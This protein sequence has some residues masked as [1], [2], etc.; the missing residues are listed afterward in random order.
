MDQVAPFKTINPHKGYAPHLSSD[1][2]EQMAERDK[3]RAAFIADRTRENENSYK[4]KKE[5]SLDSRKMTKQNGPE[6]SSIPPRM[7]ANNCGQL[8]ELLMEKGVTTLQ[9]Q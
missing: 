7:T 2:K 5:Q 3:L 8:S 6:A 4:V 1:T 9:A